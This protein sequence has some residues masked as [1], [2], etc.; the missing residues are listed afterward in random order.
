MEDN[1]VLCNENCPAQVFRGVRGDDLEPAFELY[2]EETVSIKYI[3]KTIVCHLR[4][5]PSV[6]QKSRLSFMMRLPFQLVIQALTH[7]VNMP[8][9]W[10]ES[11]W[12]VQIERSISVNL[13]L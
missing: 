4:M 5:L 10:K 6:F 13:I 8:V 2:G 9:K 3:D 1:Y 12:F 11:L 7:L